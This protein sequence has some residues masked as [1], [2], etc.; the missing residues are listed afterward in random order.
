MI[1]KTNAAIQKKLLNLEGIHDVII[2]LGYVDVSD[3][4]TLL[5]DYS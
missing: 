1:K 2:T 3:F 4:K 5:L